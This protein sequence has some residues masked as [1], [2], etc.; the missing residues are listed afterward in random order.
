[1]EGFQLVEGYVGTA[2]FDEH[3]GVV[4]TCHMSM[5]STWVGFIGFVVWQGHTYSV[6]H[7]RVLVGNSCS[8]TAWVDD[9]DGLADDR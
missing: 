6:S 3:C 7:Q 2:D 5:S 9:L 8:V 4:A 1:L